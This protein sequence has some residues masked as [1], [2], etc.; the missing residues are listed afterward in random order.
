MVRAA[1]LLLGGIA[2][3]PEAEYRGP[4]P[5]LLPADAPDNRPARRTRAP[6]RRRRRQ[7]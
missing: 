3:E 6:G 4:A 2:Q 5:Q 7:P 1:D